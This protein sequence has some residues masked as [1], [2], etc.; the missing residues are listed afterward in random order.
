MKVTAFV[1]SSLPFINGYQTQRRTIQRLSHQE[2]EQEEDVHRL[3]SATSMSMEAVETYDPFLELAPNVTESAIAYPSSSYIT[4][5]R[6]PKV[7][8][9][10]QKRF[11]QMQLN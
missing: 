4:I 6:R 2:L 3:L 10:S 9:P 11:M 8:K 1:I 5:R 7:A